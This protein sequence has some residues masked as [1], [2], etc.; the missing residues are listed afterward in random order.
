[1]REGRKFDDSME[2]NNAPQLPGW[3]RQRR[4]WRGGGGNGPNWGFQKKTSSA[5]TSS[6]GGSSGSIKQALRSTGV[7]REATMKLKTGQF[8]LYSKNHSRVCIALSRVCPRGKFGGAKRPTTTAVLRGVSKQS[9]LVEVQ[10]E[11]LAK[12][13][14][15]ERLSKRALSTS[16]REKQSLLP[17]FPCCCESP[18]CPL[19]V[20]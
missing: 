14:K 5:D 19:K 17:T 11:T 6:L 8:K 10:E 16:D 3:R 12:K 7:C 2:Q 20:Y 15:R 13:Q 1:M 9:F 18:V 4:E